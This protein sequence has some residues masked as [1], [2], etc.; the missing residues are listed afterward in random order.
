MP[1]SLR[2]LSALLLSTLALSACAPVG[3]KFM[4][5]DTP[6]AADYRS[7]A[8]KAGAPRALAPKLGGENLP[9]DWWALIPS[10]A[11]D[12]V[13]RA[14]LAGNLNLQAAR[15][16]LA[17]AT[18]AGDAARGMTRPEIDV[19]ANPQLD[20]LNLASFG[21]SGGPFPNNPHFSLYSVGATAS[22]PVDAFGGLRRGV[23]AAQAREAAAGFELSAAQ[24]SLTGQAAQ[25]AATIAALNDELKVVDQ[26]LEDDKKNLSMVR[27]AEAAGGE[28][29]SAQIGAKSQL[30]SDETLAPAL[31]ARLDAARHALAR[32]TGKTPAEFVAPDLSLAD[33]PLPASLPVSLPSELVRQRPDILASEAELHAATADIGVAVAR[34]YPNLT[35]SASLTQSALHPENLFDYKS[36]AYS[37]IAG[38]TQPVIG[39]GVLRAQVRA[40]KARNTAALIQYQDTVLSAFTQVADL[41]QAVQHDQEALAAEEKA[42][43]LAAQSLKLA[44]LAYG[45]GATGLFPVIDASRQLN[46]A[47]INLVKAQAQLRLDVIA[48][49][50]ASGK[51]IVAKTA[52]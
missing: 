31:R 7:A 43:E 33:L 50:V 3:P 23:E 52:S 6:A 51:G 46:A 17:A 38:V 12:R 20:R 49:F 1:H 37:L 39:G 41:M 8:D 10:A 45:A 26:I 22:F 32:L 29:R 35:L 11:L 5:P 16:S 9:G 18:A 27:A 4:T 24:L 47:R 25:A 34:L 40:A 21:F 36:T 42:E 2:P 19:N 13:I 28:P 15:A 44:R 14:A 30:A 48:L